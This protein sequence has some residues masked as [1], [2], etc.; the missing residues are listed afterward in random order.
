MSLRTGKTNK[1]RD[2]VSEFYRLVDE[3]K[4]RKVKEKARNEVK[5]S[6][7]VSERMNQLELAGRSKA[8]Q[9]IGKKN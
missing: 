3:E 1:K 9:P 8:V 4:Q 2:K 6:G 5:C 7:S